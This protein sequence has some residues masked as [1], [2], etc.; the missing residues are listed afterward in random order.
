MLVVNEKRSEFDPKRSPNGLTR[1][2]R[3]IYSGT[4][5][6]MIGGLTTLF[7]IAFVYGQQAGLTTCESAILSC[8]MTVL[9]SQ[10]AVMIGLLAGAVTGLFVE[11]AGHW[12]RSH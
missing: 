8:A 4:T 9:L 12:R 11:Y 5:V 10:P 3:Y 7:V 6:G 1:L 2:A